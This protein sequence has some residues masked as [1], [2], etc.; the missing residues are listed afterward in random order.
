MLVLLCFHR[1]PVLSLLHL[2]YYWASP[3]EN[4]QQRE[5]EGSLPPDEAF[6]DEHCVKSP[7]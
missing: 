4:H 6:V 2:A 5:Q 3:K 7:P 1:G